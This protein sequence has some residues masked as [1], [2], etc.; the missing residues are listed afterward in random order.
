[1]IFRQNPPTATPAGCSPAPP[2]PHTYR[3]SGLV[4]WRMAAAPF[5]V[6]HSTCALSRSSP[7]PAEGYGDSDHRHAAV[8]VQGP[9]R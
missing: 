6:I 3:A 5:S 9:G 7:H 4:L 2:Q 8:D 1:M